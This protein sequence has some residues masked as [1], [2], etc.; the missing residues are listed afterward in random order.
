M[1]WQQKPWGWTACQFAGERFQFHQCHVLAGGFSSLH[2]HSGMWNR[3]YC[4]DAIVEID[5]PDMPQRMIRVN[6]GKIADIGPGTWHRFRVIK[7]GSLWESYWG[8]C[9]LSDIERKDCNGWS[10]PHSA[11]GCSSV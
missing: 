2:R 10:P 3:I 8:D 11:T 5:L 1:I 7:S 6:P 9:D 4:R